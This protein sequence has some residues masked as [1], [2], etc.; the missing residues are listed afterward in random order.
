V[1]LAKRFSRDHDVH[2]FANT[3]DAA[4]AE[5]VRVHR[6][7]AVRANALTTILSFPIPAT[8][9]V[10]RGWDIIHAQGVASA[11]FNVITAHICNAGWARAQRA[12][13]IGRT[14]RQRTFERVVTTLEQSVY[15]LSPGA[16]VIAISNQLKG[17]LAEY[18]GRRRR[19]NVIHHGVDT[20][21]FRP[22][23][24][25]A[26]GDLRR[27]MGL[28][29]DRM[30]A[31]FVGDLRKGGAVAI[32]VL[33]RTSGV[34]LVMVSRSD[35]APYIAHARSLAVADRVVF[36]SPV[37]EIQRYYAAADIFLFPSPY[38]AFGM[39]VSEAMACGLPVITSRQAGASELIR[40]GH[41]GFVVENAGDADAF[42]T[43]VKRLA[44]NRELRAQTSRAAR[45]CAEQHTWDDVATRTMRVYEQ[46]S[47]RR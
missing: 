38:D 36:H 10:G 37:Q 20:V 32:D 30:I 45:E 27:K 25:E 16:E 13:S 31:L 24:P 15:R 35:A 11:H 34:H 3:A 19:V 6:I 17:E 42:A 26:R 44:S 18:Y 23:T 7:P 43:H 14:W 39:V 22:P 2:V 8:L 21:V 12:S 1:E 41:N 33:S 47:A 9:R 46:A 4:D 5:S 28:P 40:S 29:L